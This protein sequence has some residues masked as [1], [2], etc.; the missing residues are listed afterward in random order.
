MDLV[1]T[2]LRVANDAAYKLGTDAV[3]LCDVLMCPILLLAKTDD[4]QDFSMGQL[5]TMPLPKPLAWVLVCLFQRS[6]LEFL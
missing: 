3:L 2:L 5:L 4:L 1:W 6:D